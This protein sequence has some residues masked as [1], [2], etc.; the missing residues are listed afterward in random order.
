MRKN[1]PITQTEYVLP[2]DAMLVSKTDLKG[3]ITFANDAFIEASGFSMTDLLGKAHNLVRHPD[4]PEEAFSD[5]WDTLKVGRPW[6]ALVKNRRKNGDYYWVIANATP[7]REGGVVTGYMSVRSK[8][9]RAQVTAADELYR[10]F[11]E[12][13]AGHRMIRE[14]KVVREGLARRLTCAAG[15]SLGRQAMVAGT[16]AAGALTLALCATIQGPAFPVAARWAVAATALAFGIAG[17]S[18]LWRLIRR[19]AGLL[20]EVAA[21][22]EELTQGNFDRIFEASGEDELAA[23]QRSLQSLRT[24]VGFELAN[25]RNLVLDNTRIRQALDVAAANV[26]VA[27]SSFDIV[28]A[29][30]SLMEMFAAAETDIRQSLPAFDAA[31]VVG[32]NMD[33]F[34]GQTPLQRDTLSRLAA[35]TQTRLTLGARKLDLVITPILDDAHG[36]VGT[37]VEWTDRTRELAT[38]AQIESIVTAAAMGDLSGRVDADGLTGFFASVTTGLNGLLGTM[39]DLVSRVQ[40]AAAAVR[41]DADEISRGSMDLSER[42]GAQASALEETASSMEEMSSTAQMSAG[43]ASQADQLAGAA[44]SQA[45]IGGGV[46]SDT[47]TAMRGITDSSNK[48]ATIICVIDEIAF[49]TN[50]LALNAAVEAARAGDHG[51]GFA[52]VASEVRGLASRSAAAAKEIKGL[53]EESVNKVIHGTSLV[54]RS[55]QSLA[56]ILRAVA[57]VTDIVGEMSNASREQASGIEQVNRAVMSLDQVTQKNAA[58]VE[59]TT[60]AAKSLLKQAARLDEMMSRYTVR[61]SHAQRPSAGKTIRTAAA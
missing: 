2:D 41:S 55:G 3:H 49:Q 14:G 27:D 42:T 4:M 43:H 31:R 60:A 8:P 17:L 46:V 21:H 51:R 6:T 48:I 10:L 50:L 35:A 22:V 28:Y 1:L 44:R 7:V 16:P 40:E 56:E 19:A 18:A 9:S 13:R 37:V 23:L 26:M 57:K 25:S 29:N 12:K 58:L 47:V 11:R 20:H 45:E 52:V 59:Q 53:I 33:Q 15:T 54:D 36:R 24:K 34:H 39:A 30:R 38:E 32:A 5:L 61:D